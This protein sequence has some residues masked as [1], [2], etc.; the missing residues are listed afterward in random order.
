MTLQELYALAQE[1]RDRF[2][3]RW[4]TAGYDPT[5]GV[6]RIDVGAVGPLR[7]HRLVKALRPSRAE[8]WRG[9][10]TTEIKIPLTS[11]P[12]AAVVMRRIDGEEEN[13]AD[14]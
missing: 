7:H 6:G 12:D 13:A 3:A 14:E 11:L 8:I 2:D 10:R 4:A 1:I 5:E 9:P